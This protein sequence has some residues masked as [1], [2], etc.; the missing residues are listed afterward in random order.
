MNFSEKFKKIVTL[1]LNIYVLEEQRFWKE[2]KAGEI[3][4]SD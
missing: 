3:E 1:N 2:M 4:L